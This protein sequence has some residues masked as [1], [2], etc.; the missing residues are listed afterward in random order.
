MLW[1]ESNQQKGWCDAAW[2]EGEVY[3]QMADTG[4]SFL[5]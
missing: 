3:I 1:K 2:S 4:D 5:K